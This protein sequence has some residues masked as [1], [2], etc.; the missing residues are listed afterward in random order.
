[1]INYISKLFLLVIFSFIIAFF[2]YTITPSHMVNFDWYLHYII[3]IFIFYAVYKYI[4]TKNSSNIVS[5]TLIEVFLYFLLNLFILSI[6]FFV[7]SW[8]Q[9]FSASKWVGLFFKIL[10]YMIFPIFLIFISI[11]FWRKII[12]KIG[13]FWYNLEYSIFNFLLSLSI[14]F[15][16]FISLLFIVGLFWLYNLYLVFFIIFLFALYSKKEILELVS[17]ISSYRIDFDNHDF[18]SK[19]LSDKL[20]FNLISTEFLFLILVVVL[21][22][23]L[24]NIVRPMPIGWDDLWVYMNFP[25]QM[26]QSWVIDFLG[27]MYSWQIFTGI[28]YMISEPVQAFFLNSVWGF[29]TV[30]VL[31][32]IVSDLFSNIKSKGEKH[33]I[34]IWLLL[35]VIFISMP[36]VVFHQAKDMKVDEGLFFVSIIV[37][38]LIFKIYSHFQNRDFTSSFQLNNQ[39]DNKIDIKKNEKYFFIKLFFVAWILAWFAFSIKLTSLMLISSVIWLIFYKHIGLAWFLWYLG[40]YFAIFTK[41]R[42]W[43]YLNV[44][45]D[46]DNNILINIFSIL[47]LILWLSLIVFGVL[48][49]RKQFK[50]LFKNILIFFLWIFIALSPWFF[51]NISQ[52]LSKDL[53]VNS[54]WVILGGKGDN[55]NIDLENIYSKQ[56]LEKIEEQKEF[57]RISNSWTTQNEDFWRY[58]WYEKWINNYI[59]LPWNLTMQVNQ[60]WEFTTIWWLFLALIPALFLFL[61]FRK[62]YLEYLIL[63]VLFLEILLFVIPSSR[64]YI[65]SVMSDM[66][67][68]SG[69]LFILFLFLLPVFIFL[70]L[71]KKD[72]LNELFIA[73]LVF[74]TFYIFLFTISS[75]G[76]VWY[77]I[78]M[79]FSLLLMIWIGV[80]RISIIKLDYWEWKKNLKLFWS[81]VVFSIFLS[82]FFLSIFPYSFNNLKNAWYKYFKAWSFSFEESVFLYHPEYK[83]I[84]SV[85]NLDERKQSDIMAS[86]FRDNKNDEIINK[87]VVWN[88]LDFVST[89]SF[90][91]QIYSGVLDKQLLDLFKNDRNKLSLVKKASKNI[92]KRMYN[93]MLNPPNE[94][95]NNQNIYR[96]WTFLKYYISDN[97]S[98]LLEDSLL[99]FFW[100]YIYVENS[101]SKTIKN[102]K[103]LDLKYLLIDL[104]AATIDKDPRRNLTRRY[105]SLLDMLS[106]D[107]IKLIETDSLC[108]KLGLDMYKKSSKTPQD[109]R[110]Y[111]NLVWVNYESYLENNTK[112]ILRWIK[113][114]YCHSQIANL[115]L[116]SEIDNDNYSYL[117]NIYDWYNF[118]AD[119]DNRTKTN[120]DV[121]SYLKPRVK[122]WYKALFEVMD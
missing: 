74:A 56:E 38:Y 40:V 57:R 22:I 101:N 13:L 1:M 89:I 36:M 5:F 102:I 55:L 33:I 32:L 118:L 98:R 116:K 49:R 53:N 96:I 27:W 24:I 90:L 122:H 9:D 51:K 69:Y 61:K 19:S 66:T 100:D 80:Y 41:A 4:K 117:L 6:L 110:D 93:F 8:W 85:L 72:K 73:N 17:W 114:K 106:S 103:N 95:K 12:K 120:Q 108:L 28:W 81:V 31:I 83:K 52:I 111:L 39:K 59:K 75:F 48:K 99:N 121:V 119:R 30:I 71:L 11:S 64:S 25:R 18:K 42:L 47:S 113:M 63:S 29:L 10:W 45:Y 86:L 34:N 14:W 92:E 104:N 109:K 23:N 78:V 37:F 58:F 76:I 46:K 16:S 94:F 15:F 70:Y 67:L 82:Y 35:S 112:V 77:G 105:E 20:S 62:R 60:W 50:N 26:A 87:L 44:V 79:Y 43:D 84:L 54:I 3:P 2:Y 115:I 21:S 107:K 88:K 7:F 91:N 68:P 97:N 65:T